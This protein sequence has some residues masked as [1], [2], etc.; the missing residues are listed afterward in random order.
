MKLKTQKGVLCVLPSRNDCAGGLL[1]RNACNKGI[2]EPRN[3]DIGRG[4]DCHLGDGSAQNNNIAAA[5]DREDGQSI[6]ELSSQDSG[7]DELHVQAAS[8]SGDIYLCDYV[9]VCNEVAGRLVI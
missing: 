6:N 4:C 5:E 9:S 7:E 8:H 2:Y 3:K 1:I